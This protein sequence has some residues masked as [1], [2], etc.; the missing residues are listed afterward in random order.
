[1]AAPS[2]RSLL[3]CITILGTL[4]LAQITGH[5]PGAIPGE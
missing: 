2:P 5:T 4:E 1:M 3:E